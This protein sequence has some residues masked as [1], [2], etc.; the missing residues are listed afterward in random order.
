MTVSTRAGA[1]RTGQLGAAPNAG[2]RATILWMGFAPLAIVPVVLWVFPL[3]DHGPWL[4]SFNYLTGVLHVGMTAAFYIDPQLSAF[5]RERRRT[6]IGWPLGAVAVTFVAFTLMPDDG[7]A[8]V[9]VAFA[10]WLAHHYTG[11]QIGVATLMLTSHDRTWRLDVLDRRLI[12]ATQVLATIGLVRS[13][14]YRDTFLDG[15]PLRQVSIPVFAVL[16]VATVVVVLRG[17]GRRFGGLRTVTLVWALSF[18][19]PF[20]LLSNP[21]VAS[22]CAAAVHG[23]HYVYLV[24][25]VSGGGR[26]R[27]TWVPSV[28]V[29]T[30]VA[31]LYVILPMV[32]SHGFPA[33]V[34]PCILL[35]IVAAHRAVDARV[36]RM[37]DPERLAYLRHGLA[38]L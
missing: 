34:A 26:G 27:W 5:R 35:G 1:K 24:A 31:S 13:S 28:V 20:A 37:R 22:A 14:G 12:R 36:W 9:S 15:L 3:P 10:V 29:G 23:F 2:F 21:Y 25:L 19:A 8:L 17:A 38:F 11:Q 16:A 7:V 6:F 30:G 33:K 4:T 18:V 32:A